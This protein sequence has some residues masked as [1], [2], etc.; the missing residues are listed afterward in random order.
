MAQLKI[1]APSCAIRMSKPAVQKQSLTSG[2]VLLA[3][4]LPIVGLIVAV[5]YLLKPQ[6]TERGLQLIAVSL[7]ARTTWWVLCS[8]TGILP[9]GYY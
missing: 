1:F 7:I 3:F 2:D 4:F 9:S 8:L 6:S 5:V